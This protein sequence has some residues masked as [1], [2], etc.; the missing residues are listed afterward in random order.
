MSREDFDRAL[1]DV[2]SVVSKMD[3][4]DAE[5]ASKLGEALPVDGPVLTELAKL[6][7]Q[8]V[9]ERW[10]ADRENA[11]IRY[12]RVRKARE[13][14]ELSVDC[15]NMAMPGPGHAH[16]N[17]EIDLC[18]GVN[19]EPRFDGNPPGW[20]VYPAGS[21]HVPTVTGGEMDILYFLPGGAIE[22]GPKPGS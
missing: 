10:L 4:N 11:G 20:T 7:R 6:V 22:F 21:W 14:G 19:G 16:P 3:P 15:V 1:A 5:T 12:S 9:E 8:G 17:G 2:L 13:P 18:F